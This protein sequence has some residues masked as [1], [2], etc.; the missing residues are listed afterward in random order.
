MKHHVGGRASFIGS[1][2]ARQKINLG[3]KAVPQC[4]DSG[5][6]FRVI[7]RFPEVVAMRRTQAKRPFVAKIKTFGKG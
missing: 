3:V 1:R 6:A 4:G 2:D 7:G 5:S